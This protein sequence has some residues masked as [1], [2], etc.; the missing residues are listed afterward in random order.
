VPSHQAAE[1][2][3]LI[4]LAEGIYEAWDVAVFR[5]RADAAVPAARGSLVSVCR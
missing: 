5:P 2:Q 1:G 4:Q 3:L